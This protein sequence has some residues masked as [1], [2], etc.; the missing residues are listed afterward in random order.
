MNDIRAPAGDLE[1]CLPAN[2][3]IIDAGVFGKL[4]GG[5]WRGDVGVFRILGGDRDRDILVL[6][7]RVPDR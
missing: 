1:S 6:Q 5:V 7:D 3:I 2:R 4:C